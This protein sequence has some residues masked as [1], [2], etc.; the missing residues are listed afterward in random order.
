MKR[1][2]LL[3]FICLS[4]GQLSGFAS[5]KLPALFRNGM[6]MQRGKPIPVWGTASPGEKITLLFNNK[7]CTATAQADGNWKIVLPV[8][9]AGGPY[10][11]QINEIR[12]N[13][14]LIGDVWLCS[15]QSNMDVTVERVY[16]QYPHEIDVDSNDRIRM[17]RV[18]TVP[19]THQPQADVTANGWKTLNKQ[20]AWKFSAIGYFLAKRMFQSTGVPQGVIVNSQ[21]GT[22]IEAWISADSLQ[23]YYPQDYRTMQFYQNDDMVAHLQT[24]AISANNR[25]TELLD[26]YDPGV[27]YHW[28][29]R[30]ADDSQWRQVNQYG[31]LVKDRQLIGSLWLRQHIEIDARH[32]GKP[33]RLLL[34]TLYDQ[35]YTYINGQEVGRTSYQYPPRRYDIPAGLLQQGDNA[36]TIRFVNRQGVPHFIKEKPYMLIFGEGDTIRLNEQWLVHEGAR[37]P[38]CPGGGVS[39][40]N[41]PS[42]LYNGMLYPLHPYAVNGVVWYQGE[43]NTGAPA[44]YADKLKLMMANWRQ[45][46]KEGG[47]AELPFVIV[48]LANY[49]EPSAQPQNTGWSQIREAQRTVAAQDKRAALAVTIDLGEKVD[50]HPLRKK[51]VAERIA[52]DMDKLVWNKRVQLSPVVINATVMDNGA[53]AQSENAVAVVV[54]FD[55]T[56]QSG[57]LHEF[58]L[59]GADGRYHQAAATATGNKVTVTAQEVKQPKYIRYAWKNNPDKAD[60]KATDGLPASP[61]ERKL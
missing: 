21:G 16:P 59:A 34:G 54:T 19:N 28:T 15:G 6:V 3:I 46:W 37:M 49:M 17:F 26:S 13:D 14:I 56:L 2:F 9:K 55:R 12:I 5:V 32:A 51:E 22:P 39:L 11:M 10:A 53:A 43:S 4:L 35:D 23:K 30:T 58:E 31:P 7:R 42:T 61:F 57:T 8:M 33:C 48:Q 20:N 60:C 41:L 40:Q 44:D 29:D 38:A 25:W 36:L 27:K 50:I 47:D 18:Q 24:A 52:L 1:I 45:L